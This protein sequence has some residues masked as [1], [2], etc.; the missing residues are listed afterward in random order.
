MIINQFKKMSENFIVIFAGFLI[1]TNMC[2]FKRLKYALSEDENGNDIFIEN[3][4]DGI[5]YCHLIVNEFY[6]G[7]SNEFSGINEI[8]LL[9]EI[10]KKQEKIRKITLDDVK[11]GIYTTII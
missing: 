7:Y 8:I 10:E 11:F 9:P 3:E 2:G 5:V 4:E 6:R 1:K